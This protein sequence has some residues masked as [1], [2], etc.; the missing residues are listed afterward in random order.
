MLVPMRF[1][2]EP[3]TQHRL[4]R[5]HRWGMLLLK[6]V[7]A[8]LD[9]ATLF[10]PLSKQA[11][12]IAH[13]W[14]DR[15]ERGIVAIVMLRAAPHVRWLG[16]RKGMPCRGAT[17]LIR[18]VMGSAMRRALRA[19]D[20]RERI[21]RLNQNIEAFVARLL[22]RL[23]RGLTRCTPLLACADSSRAHLPDIFA[24]CGVAA[25]TS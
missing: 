17:S 23:P 25:D 24:S 22:K 9:E 18:A 16:P 21:Q 7:S 20:L 15:I 8:F 3:F 13:Q 1:K 4:S 10:A 2:S 19:Q 5:F 14:L 6:W 12:A 11:Q